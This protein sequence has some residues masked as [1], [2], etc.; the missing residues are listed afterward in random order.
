MSGRLCSLNPTRR[1]ITDVH[2]VGERSDR[3]EQ[4]RWLTER[5]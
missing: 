1:E 4:D 2:D 5:R 3:A